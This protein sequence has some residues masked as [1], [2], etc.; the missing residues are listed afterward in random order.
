[1]PRAEAEGDQPALV[2]EERHAE[3]ADCDFEREQRRTDDRAERARAR[4]AEI[5]QPRGE[6]AERELDGH[7]DDDKDDRDPMACQ[8]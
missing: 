1:M 5:D 3:I 7:G 8:N 4:R 6:K 2:G